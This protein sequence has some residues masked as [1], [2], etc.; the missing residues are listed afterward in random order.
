VTAGVVVGIDPGHGAADHGAEYGG[1]VEKDLNLACALRLEAALMGTP[2]VPVLTRRADFDPSWRARYEAVAQAAFVVSIHFNAARNT[3][4]ANAEGYHWPGND[5]T[6]RICLAAVAAMPL[7]LMSSKVIAAT[8]EPGPE[9]DWLQRPRVVLGAFRE[10]PCALVECG[11][12]TNPGDVE[13]L[14]QPY[15]LDEI[16]N[17]L[18]AA[19]VR[20]AKIFGG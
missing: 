3:T 14:G 12:L 10:K 16:V 19:C 17:G 18:R 2:I 15:A 9:D 13:Y 1:F 20:G 7:E 5:R 11:Y 4:Q 8:D 6:R